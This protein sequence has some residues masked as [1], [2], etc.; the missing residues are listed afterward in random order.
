MLTVVGRNEVSPLPHLIVQQ[1][2]VTNWPKENGIT[3][4]LLYSVENRFFELVKRFTD[5]IPAN[6]VL[7]ELER[8]AN[9]IRH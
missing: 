8:N 5:R 2:S 6:S 3:L 9:V 7:E 4:D 1:E